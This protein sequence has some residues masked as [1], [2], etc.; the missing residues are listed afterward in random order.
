MYNDNQ[1]KRSLNPIDKSLLL[2]QKDEAGQWRFDDNIAQKFQTIAQQE[3]PDYLRVIA[4]CLRIIA[5]SEHQQPK[6]IDVGSA[7]GETLKQLHQVGYT[8]LYGVDASADM[9]AQ[10]F[11]KATLIHSEQFPEHYAPFDYVINNWTLHFI[12]ERLAYLKAIKRSLARGGTLILTD[13]V[14]SSAVTHELYYDM[15]RANG[16]SE[17]EIKRKSAQ[18]EGILVTHPLTWYVETLNDLGFKNIEVI[19]ANTAFV[20]FMAVNPS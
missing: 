15:K 9:L 3:I 11:N 20:T 5:K 13:K 2:S 17:A 4:L 14:S 1:Y 12:H 18:I 7:L 6:I 19:N 8:N 16:V 10:S